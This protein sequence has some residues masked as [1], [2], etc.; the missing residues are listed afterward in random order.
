[1][2][3]GPGHLTGLLVILYLLWS[4]TSLGILY[5]GSTWGWLS[6]LAR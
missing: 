3:Q 5:D 6:E 1:M 4:L 2:V